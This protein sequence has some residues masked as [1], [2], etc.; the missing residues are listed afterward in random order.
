MFFPLEFAVLPDRRAVLGSSHFELQS[1]RASIPPSPPHLR[2]CDPRHLRFYAYLR[3]KPPINEFF[4]SELEAQL[5]QEHLEAAEESNEIAF[6]W[7]RRNQHDLP[8]EEQKR[9]TLY[10]PALKME[11]F[12]PTLK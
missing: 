2:S 5:G 11:D 4:D 10:T 3:T 6:Q 9:I 7:Q 1:A 8:R 12:R